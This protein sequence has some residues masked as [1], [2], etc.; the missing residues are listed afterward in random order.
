MVIGLGVSGLATARFLAERGASLIMTD[1]RADVARDHLPDGELHLGADDAEWLTD[2]E[3]VVASPGVPPTSPLRSAARAAG[4]PTISEVELAANFISMPIIGVT[5]TNG[6]STVTVLLGEI[7]K[8]AGRKPFVGGNLGT[9]LIN[10]IGGD[11]D[12]AVVELS[13]YQLETIETFRPHVGIYLNLSEDHL[14]RYS[15]LEEYGCAKARIFE[16]QA[17]SDWALLNL[18]DPMISRLANSV[19]SQVFRFALAEAAV[20][21]AIWFQS[22]SLVFDD[23]M[24]CGSIGIESFRLPGLH[25]VMN[26]MAAAAAAL[27]LGTAPEAIELALGEFSGLPHRLESI[28]TKNCVTFIDDSKATNVDAVV[29]AL[30]AT[31][32]PLILIAGGMD[33][34]GSYEPLREPLRCKVKLLILIGAARDKMHAALAG[35][36]MIECVETLAQAV[37]LAA[38]RAHQG[39][40]VLLSPACSSFDQFKDYAERG[41]LF[42]EL[43]RAL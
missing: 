40:T 17:D 18:D 2:V 27:A 31:S 34:G 43:V 26:A 3:L 14:D 33:K 29:E 11:F 38:A 25:N 5:G 10:A 28:R 36:T 23:G 6:K 30:D 32:A 1:T 19:P 37:K 7:L 39:D 13:S 22:G 41:R 15:S 42:Q 8:A 20:K 4:I 12:L 24:R 35:A 21:P 16:N 9:P